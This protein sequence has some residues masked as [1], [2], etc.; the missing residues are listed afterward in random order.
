MFCV[1]DRVADD[2]FKEGLEHTT[3]LFVDHCNNVNAADSRHLKLWG[4][5][6]GRD[7]LDTTTACQTPDRRLG[8]TLNVVAQDLAMTLGTALAESL[9]AL[10]AFQKS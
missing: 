4:T 1:C 9:S 10:S 8:D 5:H 7:T 3:R 2:T 6:T